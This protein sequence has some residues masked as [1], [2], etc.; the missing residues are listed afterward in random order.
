MKKQIKPSKNRYLTEKWGMISMSLLS[1]AMFMGVSLLPVT[2]AL[3]NQ[4]NRLAINRGLNIGFGNLKVDIAIKG[5]VTDQKTS[6]PL[7]GVS[8]KIKGTNVG[9]STDVNGNYSL[10]APENGTLVITYIG[11]VTKE[12]V[13]NNLASINI[14]LEAVISVL[15][16]IVVVGYGTQKRTTITGSVSII[17]GEDISSTPV[18]N[19]SN[20]IAGKLSGVSMRPNGGQPGKDSPDIHIRGIGTTGSNAPLIVIDGIIRNNISQVDPTI[21]ESVSIL[22]DAAAVAPYGLGGANG[23][24]LITTKK[25]AIGAPIMTFNSYSGQQTPTYY[26]KLID[27]KDFMKL[28]NEAFLNEFP[29]KTDIPYPIGLIADYDNLNAKNPDL[30]PNTNAKELFNLSG[31]PIQNHNFQLSGGSKDVKYFAGMGYFKQDGLVDDI[32]YRR[33]NFNMN[34]ESKVTKTTSVSLSLLGSNALENDVDA[35]SSGTR[36]FRSAYKHIPLKPIYFTNG[37]WG[38]WAGNSL[39]GVLNNGGYAKNNGNTLLSTISIEQQLPFIKGLS[40]KGSFSYDAQ[41]NSQKGWHKPVIYW[42]QNTNTTPYTYIK[43]I[44]TLETSAP[45][46]TYL[47]QTQSQS[48]VFTYQGFLNYQR[49]FGNHEITGL[50]VAEARN[51]NWNQFWAQ[52]N[53]F[54]IDIDELNMGSSAKTDY[55]N[56]GSSYVGAQIGYVYRLGYNYKN[57]Y[58][59]E[60]TGRYDGHYYFAPGKRWGYFPAFSAGW[61]LSEENFMKN[62]A[63]INNLKIRG[64]WGKSGNLAGSAYQYLSGYTLTGNNYAFGNNNLVQGAAS[65]REANPNITWEISTKSN[66]GF[67]ATLWNSLLTIEADY[68]SERRSGMLLS[69][70]ITLPLEYGLAIAQEN[71][72]IME[73]QG[74]DLTI[75]SNHVLQNGIRLGLN[76][77]LSIAKNKMI[78]VFETSAS[79]NNPNRRRTGRSLGIPFGYRSLGL[80][81]TQDD[82]NKDGLINTKD[83]YNIIQFG[84]LHPGDIRY[85]DLSGPAGIPDGRINAHDEVPM[86]Y[87]VNPIMSF[88]FTP[89]AAWKRF[90]MSLFFQGSARTSLDI[91]RTF[92]TVSFYNDKSTTDYEYFNNRW[93]P[94]TQDAKYPRAMSSPYSNNVQLSDYWMM[95]TSH[96]RLKTFILGYTIPS[97]AT[98][99]LKIKNVRAYI[100]GQNLFTFSNLKFNDPEMGYS[101]RETAYPNMKSLSFGANVTF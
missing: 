72:G 66:I 77:N 24:I 75:G 49:S 18:A 25:G 48:N 15:D 55:D 9:V 16:E 62:I 95:N 93:T 17:K 30:Y 5:K 88:G 41:T 31:I 34:L 22:K 46:F 81:S 35:A 45:A 14:E 27:A 47:R 68:F 13:V 79:F 26:P 7:I 100:V 56:G 91:G 52:R 38:Q 70:D 83:G 90:D 23:V 97:S 33:F 58:L 36:L 80:F 99:F 84:A 89:T 42:E 76:A 60:A 74:I 87:S 98:K 69:P 44:S 6:E 92:Q 50:I 37:L 10:N 71:A 39:A 96:L 101:N 1:L 2:A 11:Y 20:S 43:S 57:K 8:V 4:S 29:G 94:E 64:S 85:A 63:F 73:N 59:F 61:R 51:N 82:T 40:L 86:G 65:P 3:K 12:V 28:A 19:I 32:G 53:N 21:I 78:Q 67:E 54:A